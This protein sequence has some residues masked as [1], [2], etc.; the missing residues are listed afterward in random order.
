M[1]REAVHM[2]LAELGIAY[3]ETQH[4]AVYSMAE[5][6]AAAIDRLG[7]VCKNLFL[8]DDKGAQH[9]L[10]VLS[11]G[12]SADFKALAKQLGVRPL[13][14]A[15]EERLQRYLGLN[16]GEVTPLG[17]LNDEERAVTVVLD[18]ALV[19]QSKLGVHPNDNHFT[20]WLSF[21]DLCR[22]IKGHGNPLILAD[23]E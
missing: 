6:E 20:L 1:D 10:V 2:L 5:M 11:Q 7:P 4:E 3:E 22:V 13:G 15:S 18:R 19:N 12:K 23:F 16:L 17:I 8:K 21:D 9:F 14:M